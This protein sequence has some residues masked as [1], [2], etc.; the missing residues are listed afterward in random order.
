MTE[1]YKNDEGYAKAVYAAVEDT[2]IIS[3]PVP[4][5]NKS[6]KAVITPSKTQTKKQQ[7]KKPTPSKKVLPKKKPALKK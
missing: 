3:T 6:R 2:A 7:A 1:F 4:E 5:K